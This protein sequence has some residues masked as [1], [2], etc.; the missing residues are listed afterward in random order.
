MG[1][2]ARSSVPG[3]ASQTLTV[4]RRLVVLLGAAQDIERARDWYENQRSGLGEDFGRALDA[5]LSQVAKRPLASPVWP[6]APAFRRAHLPR[7]PYT[8]FFRVLGEVVEVAGVAHQKQRP[9]GWLDRRS[10]AALS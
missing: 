7:F 4:K 1:S 3:T 5:V 6:P 9:G 10:P 2:R 8:I